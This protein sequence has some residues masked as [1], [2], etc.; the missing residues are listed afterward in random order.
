MAAVLMLILAWGLA[1][2]WPHLPYQSA[3]ARQIRN[4]LEDRGIRVQSLRVERLSRDRA[5]LKDVVLGEDSPLHVGR[6]GL[7]YDWAEL[8]HGRLRTIEAEGMQLALYQA[9][10][11]WTVR[12]IESWLASTRADKTTAPPV[13][14][15]DPEKLRDVLPPHL[16]FSNSRLQAQGKQW[17]LEMPL[18]A[19]LLLT[20]Q[21]AARLES[22]GFSAAAVPYRLQSG[23]VLADAHWEEKERCWAGTVR[24]EAV[25]LTGAPGGDLPPLQISARTRLEE[26]QW[27]ADID[28]HDAK[29]AY[30][31][32]FSLRMPLSDPMAGTLTLK[33]AR[34]PWGG[35]TVGAEG[36]RISLSGHA[37]VKVTLRLHG[38]DLAGL[39]EKIG[40]GKVRAS[41]RISGELPLTWHQGGRIELHEG[42]AH[43]TESGVLALSP[44]ALPDSD[45][46][47]LDIA[48][49]ALGNFHYDSLIL[50]VVPDAR[51]NAAVRLVLKGRNPDAL[52]GRP[53][54]LTVNLTGD[55]LPLV[56]ST[57]LPLHDISRLLQNK[58]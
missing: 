53:V 7:T 16:A 23:P 50:Q 29:R 41:G 37:P 15:F 44:D 5:V 2:L 17:T 18:T 45:A 46:Q 26:K 8:R 22:L 54:K 55:L 21:P 57:L 24:M 49:E 19:A 10:D 52:E 28:L 1:A 51:G 9:K 40:G 27:T 43:A 47:A 34:M 58:P 35:G 36:A 14:S 20:E 48:R 12:G 56:Q 25:R 31:A 6:V 13:L 3:A 4:I 11:G 33:N 32:D 30:A 39:M 42:A 38:I